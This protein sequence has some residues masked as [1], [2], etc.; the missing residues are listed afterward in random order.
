MAMRRASKIGNVGAVEKPQIFLFIDVSQGFHTRKI[1]K[2]DINVRAQ[3]A[4]VPLFQQPQRPLF[5]L[6]P[7]SPNADQHL[8]KPREPNGDHFYSVVLLFL[9]FFL[10]LT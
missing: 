2:L 4:V 3:E 7:I 10:V 9:L 1:N 5:P 8:E 6:S